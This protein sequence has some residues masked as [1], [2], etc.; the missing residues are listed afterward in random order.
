MDPRFAE[1][2]ELARGGGWPDK[3]SLRRF[4]ELTEQLREEAWIEPLTRAKLEKA[5]ELAELLF[6][7]PGCAGRDG[8]VRPDTNQLRALLL[9][10]LRQ[11]RASTE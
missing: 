11:V 4:H 10:E 7:S 2:E 1:L 3:E 8:R 5:T 9:D 6:S